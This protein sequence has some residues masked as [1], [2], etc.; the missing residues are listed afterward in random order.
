MPPERTFSVSEFT[1][2]STGH[3]NLS[4][5]KEKIWSHWELNPGLSACKATKLWP[6]LMSG[7]IK[8]NCRSSIMGFVDCFQFILLL[9][10][11]NEIE[12]ISFVWF[13]RFLLASL[14][15]KKILESFKLTNKNSRWKLSQ[16]IL[17]VSFILRSQ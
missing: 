3:N 15:R 14:K 2:W 8:H 17:L 7:Y 4:V 10:N 6:H 16:I 5:K 13:D 12:N 11:T 1:L 9:R